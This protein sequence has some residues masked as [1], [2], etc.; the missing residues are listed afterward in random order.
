MICNLDYGGTRAQSSLQN[1]LQLEAT[2]IDRTL[3][4]DV[5]AYHMRSNLTFA[6]FFSMHILSEQQVFFPGSIHLYSYV[7]S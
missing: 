2:P 3:V 6:N 7:A 4:N 1:L 5:I